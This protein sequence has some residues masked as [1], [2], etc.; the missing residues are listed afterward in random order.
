MITK[1]STLMY[2]KKF[3]NPT[4]VPI[5]MDPKSMKL[6]LKLVVF[7]DKFTEREEIE[8]KTS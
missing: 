3:E 7:G 5:W 8:G 1:Y 6:F 4:N 2:C